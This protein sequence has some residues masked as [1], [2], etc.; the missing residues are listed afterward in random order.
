M[1][2]TMLGPSTQTQMHVYRV[3]GDDDTPPYKP[4]YLS[5]FPAGG[6]GS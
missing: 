1:R 2:T 3:Y 4:M 5:V 6:D